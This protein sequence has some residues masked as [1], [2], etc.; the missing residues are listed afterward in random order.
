MG[1]S[2]GSRGV[3]GRHGHQRPQPFLRGL[4]KPNMLAGIVGQQQLAQAVAVDVAIIRALIVRDRCGGMPFPGAV[5]GSRLF[6]P[7]GFLAR[8]VDHDQVGAAVAADVVGKVLK[9]RAVVV[10]IVLGRILDHRH[11]LPVGCG[12]VDGSGRDVELAVAVEVPNRDTFAAEFGF[13]LR[14]LKGNPGALFGSRQ[15][16]RTGQTGRQRKTRQSF[17]GGVPKSR[18]DGQVVSLV[19]VRRRRKPVARRRGPRRRWRM[20]RGAGKGGQRGPA[21]N[22]EGRPTSWRRQAGC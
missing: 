10:R 20:S 13:E 1:E 21:G 15:K 18:R 17:H 16:C 19:D 3:F 22:A 11:Q 6:E 2:I 12:K 7:P 5:G 14:A 4:G 9:R 8:K